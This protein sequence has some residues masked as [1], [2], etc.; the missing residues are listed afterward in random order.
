MSGSD[1]I[2][3]WVTV[4]SGPDAT[5]RVGRKGSGD[6]DLREMVLGLERAVSRLKVMRLRTYVGGWVIFP[7]T[8]L[9]E[10][11]VT[12]VEDIAGWLSGGRG[13]PEE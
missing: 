6:D 12:G 2:A 8:Q 11:H 5:Y 7:E 9:I 4:G 1:E 13:E 3:V 10:V